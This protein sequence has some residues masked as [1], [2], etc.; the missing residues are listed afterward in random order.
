MQSVYAV[1]VLFLNYLPEQG[2]E[3]LVRGLVG[4]PLGVQVRAADERAPQGD[5]AAGDGALV[6][7]AQTDGLPALAGVGAN[8][9]QGGQAVVG[10][11]VGLPVEPAERVGQARVA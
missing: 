5:Q 7:P 1:R 3:V 4:R 11:G 8:L 2:G 6:R 10:L 9:L